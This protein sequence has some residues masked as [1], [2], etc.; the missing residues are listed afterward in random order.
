MGMFSNKLF[1]L[2][3]TM[4][5]AASYQE[6]YEACVAHDSLSG[7]DDWKAKD[8]SRDYDYRLIRK[9]IQ[10]IQQARNS[11]E[12]SALVSILHEGL[13]GNLGNIANPE[14]LSYCKTGTKC[15]IECFLEEVVCALRAIYSADNS[16]ID[17]HDIKCKNT[18][19]FCQLFRM[20]PRY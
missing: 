13:H 16:Q 10:R 3:T 8:H 14:L 6:Y 20:S 19:S 12:P 15:L 11:N 17:F 2:E 5:N 4:E 18:V 1:A 9:R 7:A